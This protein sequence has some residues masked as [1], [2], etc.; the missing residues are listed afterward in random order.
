MTTTYL[1]L[2][3][4][5]LEEAQ[6]R[7]NTCDIT[8]VW[9]AKDAKTHPFKVGRITVDG[10]PSN[11]TLRYFDNDEW[12]LNC[13]GWHTYRGNTTLHEWTLLTRADYRHRADELID[14]TE[15]VLVAG[16]APMS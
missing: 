7:F 2:F 12:T 5:A 14:A 13:E 16:L 8:V 11:L 4:V 1:D 6:E 10:E 9:Q 3:Y 15:T